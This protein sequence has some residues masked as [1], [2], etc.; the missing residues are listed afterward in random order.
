MT[1]MLKSLLLSDDIEDNNVAL[2]IFKKE[3]PNYK[4]GWEI[5]E[6][7]LGYHKACKYFDMSWFYDRN[8]IDYTPRQY[9]GK[10]YLRSASSTTTTKMKP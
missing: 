2:A 5:M 1:N 8:N 6:K 9:S 3:H 4:E 7:E 10:V